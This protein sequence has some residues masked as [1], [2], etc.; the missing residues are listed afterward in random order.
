MQTT[1]HRHSHRRSPSAFTL[2]EL[3]VVIAIIAI[4][5]AMLLPALAKAKERAKKIGCV[6]NL[7]QVGIGM[8]IYA[9]DNN[10]RVL[11]A[12]S[13]G[14]PPN[15]KFVQIGIM[16]TQAQLPKEVGLDA[17]QTNGTSIW[18]CP[19]IN[20]AGQPVLNSSTMAWNISYQYF[21]G[22]SMW[23][24]PLYSGP[25]CS[26]VKLAQA[27]PTWA[28]A[29][30]FVGRIDG[31]WAGFGGSQYTSLGVGNYATFDGVAPHQ[32]AGTRYADTSNHLMADSSVGSYKWEKLRFLSSWNQATRML[33][34]Y[35]EDLPAGMTGSLATLAPT[36]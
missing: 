28:L 25:S 31:K 23:Y 34:W 15:Q 29:A 16:G 27:R 36:P 5:A 33:Y 21:G 4:L 1:E 35:Q 22:I 24:N 2:I 13:N 12:N 26:P 8:T 7:R 9:G 3:L 18:A 20:G 17:T 11:P 19:G 14:T 6:N 30:D 10:D 32:R